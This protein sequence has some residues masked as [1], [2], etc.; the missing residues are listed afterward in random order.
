MFVGGV[1]CGMAGS[2]AY[3]NKQYKEKYENL[4]E[5]DLKSRDISFNRGTNKA[6][7]KTTPQTSSQS[8]SEAFPEGAE[9]RDDTDISLIAG[10]KEKTKYPITETEFE[11]TYLE[12]EKYHYVWFYRDNALMSENYFIVDESEILGDDFGRFANA[13][14]ECWF[15]NDDLKSDFHVEM[16]VDTLEEFAAEYGI[17]LKE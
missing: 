15:R 11:E 3:F 9:D 7:D 8:L 10:R 12:Y 6:E 13:R 17:V 2:A 16:A 14:L 1:W 4:L 5:E